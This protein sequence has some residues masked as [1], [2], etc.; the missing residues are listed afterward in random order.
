MSKMPVVVAVDGSEESMRAAEWAA[1]EAVRRNA[2][3]RIVSAPAPLPRLRVA[4]VPV[5]TVTNALRGM[6]ARYLSLAIDR[7]GEVA[8]GLLI[9][10]DLLSGPPAVAVSDSGAGASVLVVGASGAGGYGAMVPGSVS[11]Y[12]AVHAS[13]PVVVVRE[14]ISAV[15]REVTVGVRDPEDSHGALD[16]AFEEAAMRRA[17]LHVVHA[18]Y[19]IA[20]GSGPAGT[21]PELISETARAELHQTLAVWRDKYPSVRVTTDVVRGHPGRVLASLSTRADLLVIGKHMTAG[22]VIGSVQ[23]GILMRARS[24]VAIVPS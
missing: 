7:V 21:S 14:D 4:D 9:E 5:T 17:E 3:L 15:H 19:W 22:R 13:C 10:T 2:P 8:Q 20:P 6:A 18:W 1:R 16:F 23:N 24:P 11:R 12:A